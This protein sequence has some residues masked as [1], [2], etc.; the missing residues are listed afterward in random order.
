MEEEDILSVESDK[1]E[2]EEE[3]HF[4]E[5]ENSLTDVIVF[6]AQPDTSRFD[7]IENIIVA[8]DQLIN[9]E[10]LKFQL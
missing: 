4:Y 7:S 9:L 8:D 5:D 10:V 6:N 3:K 1:D 2:E